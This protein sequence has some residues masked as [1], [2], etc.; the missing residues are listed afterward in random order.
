MPDSDLTLENSPADRRRERVRKAILLAAERVFRTEGEE[1]LSIRRLAEEVDYS[2]AAIYKYFGSKQELV[3]ELKN[4]FFSSLLEAMDKHEP[5]ADMQT[6][7]TD[8]MVLY[9]QVAISRPHHYTAAFSGFSPEVEQLVE[10]DEVCQQPESPKYL[11]FRYLRE[12]VEE[13]ISSGYLRPDLDPVLVAKS[14][15][16]SMHGLVMIVAH[17]PEYPAEL[18]VPSE[19]TL[20]DFVRFHCA[21]VVAGFSA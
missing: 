15:W 20:P 7:L 2:P 6:Y 12:R 4:A 1:G 14:L 13:G 11:A 17:L 9:V 18:P 3:E 19:I 8:G 21:N 16:A 5:A 10:P